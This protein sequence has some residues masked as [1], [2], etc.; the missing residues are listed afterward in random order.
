MDIP[1]DNITGRKRTLSDDDG[2]GDDDN[3]ASLQPHSKRKRITP[4]SLCLSF[5]H[6]LKKSQDRRDFEIVDLVG[7]GRK[8]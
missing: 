5:S 4:A 2:C 6:K 8:H 1:Y 3:M 7:N